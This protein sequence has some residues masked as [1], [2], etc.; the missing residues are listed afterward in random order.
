LLKRNQD[1]RI[2]D[3]IEKPQ[4]PDVLSRFVSRDD[5]ERPF[6]GS[7]GIYFFN[8]D[9]L[10]DLLENTSHHD[11]GGEVTPNAVQGSKVYGCDFDGYWEDIGTIRSFYETNLCLARP[12][13][14]FNFYDPVKPIYTRPRYLP[15]SVIDGATLHN[16]LLA[17]GCQIHD[18]DIG[19][20]IVGLRSQ[21]ADGVQMRD[22]ILMGADYYDPPDLPL[23]VVSRLA[24]GATR[25]LRVLSLTKMYAWAKM[26]LYSFFLLVWSWR[27]V[28]GQF[29]MGSLSSPRIRFSCQGPISGRVNSSPQ[30]VLDYLFKFGYYS[31]VKRLGAPLTQAFDYYLSGLIIIKRG[32]FPAACC[33]TI[34]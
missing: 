12:D 11:F 13:S 8:L 6:L 23:T 30:K 28:N 16:V 27:M 10:M 33:E 9:V 1:D 26:S 3:F 19:D 24:W 20:S 32:H 4:K 31:F 21:I 15:A 17:D 29:K 25:L 14:P 5:P 2:V 34:R 18:A 7:M 22:T